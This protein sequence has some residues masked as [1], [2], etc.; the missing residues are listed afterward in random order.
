M[1]ER[2]SPRE[3][4]RGLV[5]YK[6]EKCY[7]GYTL[8]SN[9]GGNTFYLIDMEGNVVHTWTT[10]PT[11]VGEILPNGNL[12]YGHQRNGITEVDWNNRTRLWYYP[13]TFHHDFSVMPNGHLMILC[14]VR[15]KKFNRPEL[16]GGCAQGLAYEPNYFLEIDPKTGRVFWQWWAEDH[17]EELK[18]AGAM[19]PRPIDERTKF[20]RGDI[21]HC[22]TCEVLP[23]TTLGR[24]DCRFK[25][26]NVV[27]S[28]RQID[29]MGVINKDDG[30]IV[31]AWGP[32]QLDGQHIPTLIP[33][34]HPITGEQMPGAGHFLIFDN[35]RYR[36]NFSR[37]LEVDPKTDQIVWGYRIPP[38]HFHSWHISGSDRM[39]NGNTLICD[40]PQG[41]FLEVTAQGEIVWEYLNPFTRSKITRPRT[42][43][44]KLSPSP[45][46]YSDMPPPGCEDTRFAVYR[47]V[48][49]P[50][51][52]IEPLL[53]K[54]K[55]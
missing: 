49:Y 40:G 55:I 8:F 54:N 6:P 23:D 37:I 3:N 31:W 47:C 21:F 33:D 15:E 48:R 14:G 32:G 44:R 30:E 34:F 19:F 27:F 11:N 25:A 1:F 7:N 38:R 46:A 35:G 2:S 26:G 41:R 45:A 4:S 51:E 9:C 50:P 39:P 28:Y 10:L 42:A 29:T 53:E 43:S 18:E 22:N 16:F 52:Y 24:E 17:T 5:S 13:C 12:I 20:L 36:R